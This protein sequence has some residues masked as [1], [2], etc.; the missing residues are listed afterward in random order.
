MAKPWIGIPTRYHDKTET[1]GQI[2]HYLDAIRWAGGIPLMI[3]TVDSLAELNDYLERVDGIIL[4]GSPTDID[5]AHYGERP[6]A[7]L[8]KAYPERDALDFALLRHSEQA[9][10]PVLG[11][12]FGAQSLNVFR[13]GSLIQDIPSMVP[14]PLVHE[15]KG[16]DPSQLTRHL[17]RFDKDSLLARLAGSETAE[18]VSDHHQSIRRAGRDLRVSATAPDGVVEAVEDT[19]GRF[20]IG[21]QWHPE[22]GWSNDP[23]SR[24]IFAALVAEAANSQ[25]KSHSV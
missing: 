24:A 15:S 19:T 12:C 5:P 9:G 20:F 25:S 4:P 16:A 17:V 8:G 3:P 14:A 1:L 2:R 18:V 23:L 7:R 11:I 13:G 22:R 21:I 10:V 6:H